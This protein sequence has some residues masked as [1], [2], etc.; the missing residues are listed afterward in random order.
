MAFSQDTDNPISEEQ[1]VIR[2][3]IEVEGTGS[4]ESLNTQEV[5]GECDEMLRTDPTLVGVNTRGLALMTKP[6]VRMGCRSYSTTHIGLI[7]AYHR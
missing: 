4:K 5:E 2:D 7:L 1:P 6:L 3:D